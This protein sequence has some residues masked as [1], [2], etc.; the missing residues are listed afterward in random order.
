[1]SDE[2]FHFPS[3]EISTPLPSLS[4]CSLTPVPLSLLSSLPP[5]F[6]LSPPFLPVPLLC[7]PVPEEGE[8]ESSAA[9]PSLSPP[10]RSTNGTGPAL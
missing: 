4:I 9:A 1:M 3:E 7:S 6:H 10:M 5:S 2:N 8:I